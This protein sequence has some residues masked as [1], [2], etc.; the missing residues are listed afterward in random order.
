MNIVILVGNIASDLELKQT[1]TGKSVCTFNLA[2]NRKGSTNDE[3][4]F[5]TVIAWGK[6]AEFVCTYLAK[7][8]KIAVR[9]AVRTRTYEDGETGKH[10][11]VTEIHTDDIEACDS[12]PKPS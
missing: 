5:P 1:T 6:T 11:K 3:A 4:D 8:R 10:H 9:G 12:R 7:G 2:I